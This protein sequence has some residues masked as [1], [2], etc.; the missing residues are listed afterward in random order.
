MALQ[1]SQIN[2]IKKKLKH[3]LRMPLEE[4]LAFCQSQILGYIVMQ[5]TITKKLEIM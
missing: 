2:I 5:K 4:S 3:A 1:L